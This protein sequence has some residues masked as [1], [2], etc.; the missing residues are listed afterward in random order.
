VD[1]VAEGRLVKGNTDDDE[2]VDFDGEDKDTLLLLR[3]SEDRETDDE[4][5]EGE[6]FRDVTEDRGLWYD[7]FTGAF[8][9]GAEATTEPG[10]ETRCMT[11]VTV[12]R[13]DPTPD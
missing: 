9:L 7:W 11:V 3:E 5:V 2:G 8:G 6:G 4:E 13:L 1:T 10:A 12:I